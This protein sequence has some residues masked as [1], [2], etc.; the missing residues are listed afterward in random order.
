MS[1]YVNPVRLGGPT[2]RTSAQR[3]ANRAAK[4]AANAEIALMKVKKAAEHGAYLKSLMEEKLPETLEPLSSPTSGNSS[5]PSIFRPWR[6][7]KPGSSYSNEEFFT[8]V[9]NFVGSNG[10]P[11]L[12]PTRKPRVGGRR[13]QKHRKSR[14][15]RRSHR[16]RKTRSS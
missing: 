3:M 16:H 10:R 6:G 7:V 1:G 15:H 9:K 8:P 13:T 14:K 5:S 2:G 4:N 11:Q 12:Q